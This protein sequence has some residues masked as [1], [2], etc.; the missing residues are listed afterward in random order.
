MTFA[1]RATG[2]IESDLAFDISGAARLV[3]GKFGDE[4]MRDFIAAARADETLSTGTDVA[5]L[6]KTFGGEDGAFNDINSFDIRGASGSA[7]VDAIRA[8]GVGSISALAHVKGM[9]ERHRM[10]DLD[11]QLASRDITAQQAAAIKGSLGDNP[12][13]MA[14][15]EKALKVG[16]TD[17]NDR[18]VIEGILEKKWDVAA[19]SSGANSAREVDALWVAAEDEILPGR[20]DDRL[21]M[22]EIWKDKGQLSGLSN[23]NRYITKVKN[24]G[25]K[26]TG[27]KEIYT[28]L[29]GDTT[30]TV[31]EI[32][33]FAGVSQELLDAVDLTKSKEDDHGAS[34]VVSSLQSLTIDGRK[35]TDKEHVTYTDILKNKDLDA[36][37]KIGKARHSSTKDPGGLDDL[38]LAGIEKAIQT[39]VDLMKS[40]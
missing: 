40:L 7:H 24:K 27:A 26:F 36:L 3:Q 15:L 37:S 21:E 5:R 19:K 13:T 29:T 25:A 30:A 11:R 22:Q 6:L 23:L 16:L 28:A 18:H 35:M 10:A 34:L 20:I 32:A 12:L 8:T 4:K 2:A 31:K 9:E 14:N 1:R 33:D 17:S 38:G 39:I